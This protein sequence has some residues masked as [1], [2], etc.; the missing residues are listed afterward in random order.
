[1]QKPFRCTNT[2]IMLQL[3]GIV[4]VRGARVGLPGIGHLV[5]TVSVLLLRCSDWMGLR[6]IA[7]KRTEESMADSGLGNID[8]H[9]RGVPVSCCFESR[10]T[11][12][13]GK[14]E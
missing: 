13:L 10:K 9:K 4:V 3:I 11:E 12:K 1:M 7:G 5:G 2:W 14:L 6:V 8:L